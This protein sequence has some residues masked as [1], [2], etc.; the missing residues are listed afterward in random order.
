MAQRARLASD[1][2]FESVVVGDF[3]SAREGHAAGPACG[4][5]FG[6]EALFGDPAPED[7]IAFGVQLRFLGVVGAVIEDAA[8]LRVEDKF[9]GIEIAD[10][11]EDAA[12][13]GVKQNPF[14]IELEKIGAL[15]HFA[16]ADG[17]GMFAA[18]P[19]AFGERVEIFPV[20]KVF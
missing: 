9:F 15:P 14:F 1:F 5:E 2:H 7:A 6:V 18:G 11:P 16:G 4:E 3:E 20:P 10:F 19:L 12:C 17:V 8:R 13:R